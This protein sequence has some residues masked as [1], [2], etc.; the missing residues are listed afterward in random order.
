MSFK[1]NIYRISEEISVVILPTL[2]QMAGNE[3]TCYGETNVRI[4]SSIPI[5]VNIISSFGIGG[6]YLD[7]TIL[8]G[9]NKIYNDVIN[10]TIP[11]GTTYNFGIDG[12]QS[13]A[14]PNYS[15]IVISI[16]DATTG[17]EIDSITYSRL[18]SNTPC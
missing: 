1:K 2:I 18:H 15:Q 5:K 4:I 10:Q 11:Y 17:V 14:A 3:T 6:S 13:G 9:V 12:S 8:T 7:P 16:N